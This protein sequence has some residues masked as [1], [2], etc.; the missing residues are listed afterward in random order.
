[1]ESASGIHL[2]FV[3]ASAGADL[4]R[5]KINL[6]YVFGQAVQTSCRQLHVRTS[7]TNS[8][9]QHYAE[10]TSR[11]LNWCNDRVVAPAELAKER[12]SELSLRRTEARRLTEEGERHGRNA[13]APNRSGAT[14]RPR[15][16]GALDFQISPT[17]VAGSLSDDS[18]HRAVHIKLLRTKPCILPDRTRTGYALTW[19]RVCHLARGTCKL[20]TG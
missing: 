20:Q 8:C 11:P 10:D 3:Q 12:V 17:A 2:F 13:E 6:A 18:V 16:A 15:R 5:P 4:R 19:L 1:M 7:E 14:A 9:A